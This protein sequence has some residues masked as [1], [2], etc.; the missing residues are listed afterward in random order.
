MTRG[1]CPALSEGIL[2]NKNDARV[3]YPSAV[4]WNAGKTPPKAQFKSTA[5]LS[6]KRNP[7]TCGCSCF[8]HEASFQ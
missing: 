8:F 3:L 5:E 1:K 6:T 4:I 7:R 2:I